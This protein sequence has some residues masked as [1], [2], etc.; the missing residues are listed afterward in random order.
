MSD[1]FIFC[2]R[3]K[4]VNTGEVDQEDISLSFQL[5]LSRPVLHRDAGK[6]G[7]FLV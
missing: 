2:A 6:I 1:L 5:G 4:A 7:N 3:V